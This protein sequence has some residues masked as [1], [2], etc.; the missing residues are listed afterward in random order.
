MIDQIPTL[1]SML[2][3]GF[4]KRFALE[5][6][7]SMEKERESGLYDADFLAWCHAH[8]FL[9][10]SASIYP[11]LS[12]QTM[13]D[14]LTDYDFAR[15]WPL[16]DWPRMWINDKLTFN[17]LFGNSEFARYIPTYFY[18]SQSYR[19]LPMDGALDHPG[20]DGFLDLLR[21][22]GAFACKPSNSTEAMGFFKLSWDGT[23]YHVNSAEADAAGIVEFVKAHPNYVF[24][25]YLEPSAELA[26]IDPLIHM[27][28]VVVVNPAGN[29]PQPIATYMR[30]ALDESIRG[31]SANYTRPTH[32]IG[33]FNLYLDYET[34]EFGD[35]KIAYAD[36]IVDSPV[37]PVSGV[38]AEGKVA[39]WDEIE[40][41]MRDMALR[42][43]ACEFLGYD[44]CVTEDGPKVYE[45]NSHPG[46]KFMQPFTPLMAG[47]PA[48]DYFQMK[49][50]QL[51]TVKR[52]PAALERRNA[53][54]R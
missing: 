22:K 47:G 45:I 50:D 51:E 3:D 32:E 24:T 6:L 48:T 25:E 40:Q 27:M 43:G 2:A 13:D 11:G 7:A 5:H 17:A 49:L 30:F 14:Y 18:Y 44:I 35:A 12:E 10:G 34:G 41:L 54:V 19:L 53:I 36:H 15:L 37:H 26:K 16:N 29:D 20:Y 9:A 4:T 8:G 39:C 31:E 28:R 1:E 42:I 38:R 33:T 52:D 23:A 21:E 46:I